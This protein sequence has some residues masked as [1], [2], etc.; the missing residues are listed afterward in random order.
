MRTLMIVLVAAVLLATPAL[1]ER[2]YDYYWQVD[3][4]TFLGSFDNC[5]GELSSDMNFPMHTGSAL[6]LTKTISVTEGYSTG[7]L[8]AVWNLNEGDQV[9][10]SYWRYDA[11]VGYPR[12]RLWAHYN[13]ALGAPDNRSHD[14][15]VNDG[16]A[17]GNNSFGYES[18]WEQVSYTWTMPAGHVGL[19]ID[20]VIYG[21]YG[22]EVYVDDMSI[23]VPDN[24]C[25]QDPA[26]YHDEMGSPT[27]VEAQT[28][29]TV[30]ALFQ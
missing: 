3:G 10:Y 26:V 9:T 2:T 25:V 11:I 27:A 23:T 30:K 5:T 15:L 7:F 4:A 28:W 18:G 24:A 22:S 16:L 14:M 21:D 19:V 12:V 13:D 8:A 29:G 1:A 17:Y 6:K 20:C